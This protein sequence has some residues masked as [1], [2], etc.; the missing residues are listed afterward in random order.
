MSYLF[1]MKNEVQLNHFFGISSLQK[2]VEMHSQLNHPY[3]IIKDLGLPQ[4]TVMNWDNTGLVGIKRDSREEWRRFSLMD[5]V[6]LHVIQEMRNMGVPLPL[7]SR[8]K[9]TL[10]GPISIKWVFDLLKLNP[11]L[12][13]NIEGE[14][15]KSELQ[16]FLE[17]E[18]SENIDEGLSVSTLM[19]L[20]VE[21]LVKK[22]PISILVFL[23]GVTVPWYED[24]P[25]YYE[26]DFWYKKTQESY[27]SIPLAKILK[28]F[29]T[30]PKSLF[31]LNK[32]DVM[33]PNERQLMEIIHEGKYEAVTIHFKDKKMKSLELIKDQDV[34]KRIV[35]VIRD[36][37]Y[38]DITIKTHA[39][40]VTKVQNKI[41]VH[42]N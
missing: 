21:C 38:Q 31:V 42:F 32:M 7:V 19:L 14:E 37:S 30:E 9:E 36:N 22:N 11:T 17:F 10:L 20:T 15:A 8:A 13:D 40:R 12:L 1:T 39:G 6:W 18:E 35:D 28:S 25:E 26:D 23:D 2:A 5:Y 16:H 3:L 41:K 29:L 4:R 24:R 33:T 27:V 34:T